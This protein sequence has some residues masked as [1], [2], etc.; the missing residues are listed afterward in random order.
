MLNLLASKVMTYVFIGII[1]VA[2]IVYMIFSSRQR[3][4]QVEE[5]RKKKDAICAGTK[6]ITIGGI[7]GT[8]VAVEDSEFLLSSEGS[9]IRL[10]K[11]AIYQM[12]L[13]EGV[14]VNAVAE[15]KPEEKVEE[16]VEEVAPAQDAP[17]TLEAKEGEAP[18][19]TATEEVKTEEVKEEAEKAPA[20]KPAAK[21]T[22][23]KKTTK[24]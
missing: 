22:S 9:V 18:V 13:P 11:R 6:V 1:V 16:K 24:K 20:K 23:A 19:E 17:A 5:D 21:K 12:E 3:K 2:V 4:K 15:E 10:D 7:V 8:V 14:N